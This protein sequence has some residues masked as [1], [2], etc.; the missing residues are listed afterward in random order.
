MSQIFYR[1]IVLQIKITYIKIFLDLM[2]FDG[3]LSL[4][5]KQ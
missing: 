2:D 3:I 4:K 5:V 1:R